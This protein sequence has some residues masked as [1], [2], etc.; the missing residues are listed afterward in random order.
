M[1]TSGTIKLVPSCGDRLVVPDL[2]IRG[3]A[4]QDNNSLGESLCN[5]SHPPT[6]VPAYVDVNGNC[7]TPNTTTAP[8]SACGGASKTISLAGFGNISELEFEYNSYDGVHPVGGVFVGF[9]A[10]SLGG[11]IIWSPVGTTQLIGQGDRIIS[12]PLANG[13]FAV[14]TVVTGTLSSNGNGVRTEVAA[15]CGYPANSYIA[16]HRGITNLGDLPQRVRI[17]FY[18]CLGG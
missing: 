5:F 14:L 13:A 6:I 2:V 16:F 11:P 3:E 17:E 15:T 1:A 8:G 4:F 12:A 18:N 9:S 7:Y 10:P